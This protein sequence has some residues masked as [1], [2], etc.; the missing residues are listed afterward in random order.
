MGIY[1]MGE[2]APKSCYLCPT[3][4]CVRNMDIGIFDALDEIHKRRYGKTIPDDCPIIGIPP[5]SRLIDAD[6]LRAFKYHDLPYTHIY[7]PDVKDAESY[8]RGW[9][10]AV[11]MV[12]EHAAETIPAEKGEQE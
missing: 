8:E 12:I 4:Y 10:D 9:N 7:P 11:D 1:I 5:D 6:A 2:T 3:A